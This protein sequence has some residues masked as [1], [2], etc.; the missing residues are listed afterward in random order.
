MQKGSSQLT[1]KITDWQVDVPPCPDF[2]DVGSKHKLLY[3]C[4]CIYVFFTNLEWLRQ[5]KKLKIW[6]YQIG[7]NLIKGSFSNLKQLIPTLKLISCLNSVLDCL[8]YAGML[9]SSLWHFFMVWYSFLWFYIT[10]ICYLSVLK[11]TWCPSNFVT[12]FDIL[13][14]Q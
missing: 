12:L 4:R 9:F 2:L 3:L 11:L 14:H 7:H 13:V 6:I 8:A 5:P 10:L 1:S